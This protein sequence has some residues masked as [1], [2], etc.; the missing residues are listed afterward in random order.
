MPQYCCYSI[1][2]GFAFPIPSQHKFFLYQCISIFVHELIFESATSWI[3]TG[4]EYTLSFWA[5]C[6]QPTPSSWWCNAKRVVY[7]DNLI[8]R[9]MSQWH[10]LCTILF[11]EIVQL[12]QAVTPHSQIAVQLYIRQTKLTASMML[13]VTV[14]V[15][16]MTITITV[17]II[18]AMALSRCQ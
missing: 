6:Y 18:M 7:Y 5:I 13:I 16:V 12:A 3:A 2:Y 8:T 1:V 4:H 17:M 10:V 11:R 9:I 14:P 15:K